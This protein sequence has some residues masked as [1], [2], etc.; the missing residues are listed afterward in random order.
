[1][2]CYLYR[3]LPAPELAIAP[4]RDPLKHAIVALQV[5]PKN[6]IHIRATMLSLSS[7][8][9]APASSAILIAVQ[10]E[11]MRAWSSPAAVMLIRNSLCWIV[12]SGIKIA[13]RLKG[14]L[15]S[16]RLADR[17]RQSLVYLRDRP[18]RALAVW[19]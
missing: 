12:P 18:A 17:L 19:R 3:G 10:R 8:G 9:M 15:S 11:E 14:T 4:A 16:H 7:T 5:N 6:F 13:G 1:V 2:P